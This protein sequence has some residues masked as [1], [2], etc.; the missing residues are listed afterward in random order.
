MVLPGIDVVGVVFGVVDVFLGTI[1]AEP[2]TGD[3]ELAGAY[4][5]LSE[6]ALH[7]N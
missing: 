4:D 3:L 6:P 1:A 5:D 2:F 7:I